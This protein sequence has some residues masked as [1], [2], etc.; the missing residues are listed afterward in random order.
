MFNLIDLI[1]FAL[2]IYLIWQG[3]RTGF[4]GGVLNL[5][6]TVISLISAT[7]FYP[8]LGTFFT[9][10]FGWGQN[11]SQIIAF[12]FILIFLEV[13]LGFL[14]SRFYG[15]LAP[16]Y[17]KFQGLLV[18]DR[19][20]G[21]IPSVLVGLF[22]ASLFLLLPLILPV[23][24]SLKRPIQESWW[25][26]NVLPLGLKYQP[27]LEKYLNRLPYQNLVYLITPE[28]SSEESV[29]IEI[30]E[31]AEFKVDPEAEKIML[32][33]VNRERTKRG[34]STLKADNPLRDVGRAHCLDM[35]ERSYFSHYT[36]EG[37]S[38][39][40]RMQKAKIQYLVAG[41]NLAY[42]PTVEIAHQG[43]M[44]SPGH[45]ENILRPEFGTLGVGVI[46]GGLSG[47]MFCQ[48]FSD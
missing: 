36:L 2:G 20:L 25:G 23:Q 48:E 10:Q 4:V 31:K 14:S 7:L 32:E 3:W 35:F 46:D 1:I 11:L 39:F 42:A 22:L 17:K 33:L 47:K 6:T 29:S 27:T 18:V 43:L 8:S 45:K 30:P 38:P 9:N 34:L 12:F 41:E 19:A 37:E 16:F 13:T 21:V 5:L 24:A 28:P 44:N 15:V 26:S 40:D